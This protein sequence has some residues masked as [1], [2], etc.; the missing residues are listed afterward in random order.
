MIIYNQ[1]VSR[2][3]ITIP[4]PRQNSLIICNIYI[5][6]F[7][8]PDTNCLLNSYFFTKTSLLQIIWSF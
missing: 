1:E 3:I 6:H 4:I 8:L 7:D 5:F 2:E